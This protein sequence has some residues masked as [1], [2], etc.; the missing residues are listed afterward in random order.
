MS[1]QKVARERY[2]DNPEYIPGEYKVDMRKITKT[3]HKK[4]GRNTGGN[5]WMYCM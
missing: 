5:V 1:V 3:N 4:R 2:Q